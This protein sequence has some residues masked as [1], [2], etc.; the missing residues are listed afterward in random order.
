[1]K[2]NSIP[3]DLN[4]YYKSRLYSI[5]LAA[6]SVLYAKRK[7]VQLSDLTLVHILFHFLII[8]L[9]HLLVD[10]LRDV[11]MIVVFL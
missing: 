11:R 2:M 3:L 8:L 4:L 5:N 1:M 9:T 6:F 10:M 7:V